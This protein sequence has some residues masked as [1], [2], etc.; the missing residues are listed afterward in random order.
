MR[1]RRRLEQFLGKEFDDV[2][3][4]YQD[5]VEDLLDCKLHV[6]VVFTPPSVSLAIFAQLFIVRTFILYI[7]WVFSQLA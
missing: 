3:E 2:I 5:E 6:F 7:M 1:V 4:D